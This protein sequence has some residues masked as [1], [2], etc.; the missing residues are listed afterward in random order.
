M[1]FSSTQSGKLNKVC[2]LEQTYNKKPI[3]LPVIDID[4]D[5]SHK[6]K[7][8]MLLD[9]GSQISLINQKS[10]S[11]LSIVNPQNKITI[12]SLHGSESTLG[13]VKAIINKDNLQIPIQLQV[14]RNLPLKEDGI[15]GY[16]ILSENSIINGPDKTLTMTSTN[17]EIRFPITEKTQENN[18]HNVLSNPEI[19]ILSSNNQEND[20]TVKDLLNIDY[21]CEEKDPKYLTNLQKVK[22]ITHEINETQI[23]IIPYKFI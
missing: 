2:H 5:I 14:T 11:D 18:L 15:I 3:N 9:T 12:N 7:T 6:P 10:I 4:L 19:T 17:S 16:D 8:S 13:D 1:S 23:K 20:F 21:S 22:N